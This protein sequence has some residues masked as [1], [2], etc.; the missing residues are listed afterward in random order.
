[1]TLNHV[2]N[3][4]HEVRDCLAGTVA[5]HRDGTILD[6]EAAMAAWVA[7]TYRLRDERNGTLYFIGNGASATMAEHM[8]LDAMKAGRIRTSSCSE[9]AYLTAIANDVAAD[10]LFSFK[11]ERFATAADMLVTISSSGNS[12][13]IIRAIDTVA[14]RDTFV[15]TLSAM[16]PDNASRTRGDLNFYVPAKTYGLAEVCHGALLHCWLDAFLDTYEGGR[17]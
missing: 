14:P 17:R 11:L 3:Y 12:P 4:I 15:V 5:T 16:R 8:T 6:V 1:M 2:R 10:E 9:T 7:A 13:N